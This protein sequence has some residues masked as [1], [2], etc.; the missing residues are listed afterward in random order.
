MMPDVTSILAVHISDGVLSPPYLVAGFVL[1]ALLIVPA[2]WR[3]HEDEIP[4]IGLLTTAIFVAS[5]IHVRFGITSVHLL[6]NGLVGIVLGTRSALAVVVGLGLQALLLGH[7]GF[8]SLGVNAVVM[9]VP[10]I[11]ARGV[12]AVTAGR[13]R[14]PRPRRAFW[15][16]LVSGTFAVLLTAALNAAVL[17]VAGV[18]DFRVVAA[19]VLA[20]HLPI[21]AI[22]GVIVGFTASYLA[23]VK[24][25]LL[26]PVPAIET[27][28]QADYRDSPRPGDSPD[29]VTS[30]RS[31]TSS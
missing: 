9:T 21:A 5:L 20:A 12:F 6:L 25:E 15:A 4:R 13:T 16:G 14:P 31:P 28:E 2:I 24:P 27:P 30:C 8:T 26:F 7:G 22:E 19:L 29:D 3:V 18:E 10:A 23:R 11:A 1:A 17:V